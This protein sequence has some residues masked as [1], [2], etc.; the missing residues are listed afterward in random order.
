MSKARDLASAHAGVTALAPNATAL[1]SLAARDT[2]LPV[3]T[4][5]YFPTASIPNGWLIADG[6]AVSR[7]TYAAL[8]AQIGTTYGVG[9]GSTTFNLPDGRGRSLI[10]AG[11]GSGLTNRVLGATGGAETHQLTEA[12]MPLHGHPVQM[13][14]VSGGSSQLT[15]GLIVNANSNS[16]TQPAYT[17]APSNSAGQQIGG[18][19]GGQSHNNMQ[20]FLTVNMC[21]YAGG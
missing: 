2:L 15:G 11:Q 6:S 16:G 3:G 14:Y 13:N 10:G 4:I 21:I 17:G 7:S 12:Q 8:F 1:N 20:P 18:A 5:S 19:G 9:D